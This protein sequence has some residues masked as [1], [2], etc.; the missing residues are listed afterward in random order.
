MK[1]KGTRNKT[2]KMHETTTTFK[3]LTINHE[4]VRARISHSKGNGLMM[5]WSR[6][7]ICFSAEMET[8]ASLITE[9]SKYQY[10]KPINAL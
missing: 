4:N 6:M 2:L 8:A 9:L 5:S 10:T 3:R 1:L 7:P